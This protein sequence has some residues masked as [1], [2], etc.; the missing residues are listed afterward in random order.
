[1]SHYNAYTSSNSAKI[2]DPEGLQEFISDHG[3]V[4]TPAITDD[5]HIRI[6][7]ESTLD[8]EGEPAKEFLAEIQ[9]ALEETLVVRSVGYWH[10]DLDL[11][12]ATQWVVEPEGDIHVEQLSHPRSDGS[13]AESDDTDDREALAEQGHALRNAIESE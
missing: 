1:M 3:I 11:P 4:P 2:T 7:G 12:H 8:F 10:D 13:P 6:E 5:D 9:P